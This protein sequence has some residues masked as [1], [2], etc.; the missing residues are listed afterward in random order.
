MP[1]QTIGVEIITLDEFIKRGE[2]IIADYP[3]SASHVADMV[4]LAKAIHSDLA[5]LEKRVREL[6]EKRK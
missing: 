4:A 2:K 1:K 6:E 5:A 3:N